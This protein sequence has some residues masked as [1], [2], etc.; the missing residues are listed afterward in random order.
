MSN[1]VLD[2]SLR[3]TEHDLSSAF[4]ILFLSLLLS[5]FPLLPVVH[6]SV[7]VYI[8]ERERGEHLGI[9]GSQPTGELQRV[10]HQCSCD[11]VS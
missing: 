7:C 3:I 2:G 8:V 4:Q 1:D 11:C 5:F 9:Q 10:K 6:L